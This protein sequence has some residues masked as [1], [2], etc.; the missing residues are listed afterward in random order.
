[1]QL[2][3]SKRFYFSFSQRHQT[4]LVCLVRFVS[5][6]RTVVRAQARRVYLSGYMGVQVSRRTRMQMGS[7]LI[8]GRNNDNPFSF[9]AD[10]PTYL[11]FPT[12][13]FIAHDS[14]KIQD[15]NFSFPLLL[16]WMWYSR[17][18]FEMFA[19]E[20]STSRTENFELLS[21][22]VQ[23][24]LVSSTGSRSMHWQNYVPA[25]VR[26]YRE[27]FTHVNTYT[28]PVRYEFLQCTD[29]SYSLSYSTGGRRRAPFS[30]SSALERLVD[31]SWIFTYYPTF[32]I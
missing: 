10:D 6:P 11:S 22:V 9:F 28:C 1:M 2:Y 23:V 27:I 13:Q 18:A 26:L 7:Q 32:R 8:Q 25:T 15:K 4:Q 31:F 12:I 14:G 20:W 24:I 19:I 5:C 29:A 30:T 16:L 21:I 17:F 3:R